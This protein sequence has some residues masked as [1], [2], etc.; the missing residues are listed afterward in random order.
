MSRLT[1]LFDY[2]PLVQTEGVGKSIAES[3]KQHASQFDQ[4][5]LPLALTEMQGGLSHHAIVAR[6]GAQAT[7]QLVV[8]RRPRKAITESHTSTGLSHEYSVL[9]DL[10]N[11][12]GP[13]PHY[14]DTQDQEYPILAEEYVEGVHAPYSEWTDM[15]FL[16]LARKLALLHSQQQAGGNP[17]DLHE[18][19]MRQAM[20]QRIASIH[21][22][23]GQRLKT[24]LLRDVYRQLDNNQPLFDIAPPFVSRIHNDIHANNLLLS[25]SSVR[26]IDWEYADHG[27]PALELSTVYHPG[28]SFREYRAAL[29]IS[30]EQAFLAAYDEMTPTDT[31]RYERIQMGH[32]I[33]MARLALALTALAE[34]STQAF[35]MSHN[36]LIDERDGLL[37]AFYNLA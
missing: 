8:C 22:E 21:S 37:D 1:A 23:H 36:E 10:A 18:Y 16:D 28:H 7:S 14:L 24:N 11:G 27:D 35:G 4:F 19:F 29:D 30:Q 13:Q 9:R 25:G 6:L 15:A 2:A 31:T 5:D 20:P 33:D 32:A 26:L 17:T 3:L 34:T 12:I